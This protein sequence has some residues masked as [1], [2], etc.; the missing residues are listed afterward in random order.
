MR[1][2]CELLR[3]LSNPPD[4]AVQANHQ[5]RI[6]ARP[7]GSLIAFLASV[8]MNASVHVGVFFRANSLGHRSVLFTYLALL[9]L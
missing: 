9:L 2:M 3:K 5:D 4:F 8:G 7:A 6:A 1:V